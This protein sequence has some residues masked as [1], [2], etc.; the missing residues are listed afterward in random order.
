MGNI[1]TTAISYKLGISVCL[2][3]VYQ[4]TPLN[5]TPNSWFCLYHQ[6]TECPWTSHTTCFSLFHLQGTELE[7]LTSKSAS[8]SAILLN[9]KPLFHGPL[10]PYNLSSCP[11]AATLPLTV[12]LWPLRM[13]TLAF[14]QASLLT[15]PPFLVWDMG[16]WKFFK[17]TGP[18]SIP[19]PQDFAHSASAPWL[20]LPHPLILANSSLSHWASMGEV[21]S[22]RKPSLTFSK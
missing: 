20:P 16:M 10:L 19:R 4:H 3:P 1:Y 13:V 18:F 22:P 12:H 6:K 2:K 17:P 9:S 14:P 8:T 5:Y 15:R 7:E 21:T 11:W